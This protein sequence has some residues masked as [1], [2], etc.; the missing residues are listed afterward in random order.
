[1][2]LINNIIIAIAAPALVIIFSVSICDDIL[3]I[4]ESLREIR[5][6]RRG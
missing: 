3:G 1:M 4:R 2:E 6:E 5:R